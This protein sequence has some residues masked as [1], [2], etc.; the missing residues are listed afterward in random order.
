MSRPDPRQLARS[1]GLSAAKLRRL[2]QLRFAG[3]IYVAAVTKLRLPCDDVYREA[4]VPPGPG[5][6]AEVL[7]FF[8]A[9]SLPRNTFGIVVRRFVQ[10][11]RPDVGHTNG[12]SATATWRW[13]CSVPGLLI[14][15]LEIR[16]P[17]PDAAEFD[18][19]GELAAYFNRSSMYKS[20]RTA[21]RREQRPTRGEVPAAWRTAKLRTPRRQVRA[22][23]TDLSES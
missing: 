2:R 3:G 17:N 13:D 4:D 20:R 8:H 23:W 12:R 10:T 18:C 1:G 9:S 21:F 11:V 19:S 15:A 16:Q 7:T 5:N 6:P 22:S 14:R